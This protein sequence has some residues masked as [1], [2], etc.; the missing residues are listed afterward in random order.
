MFNGAFY[1]W[2][3]N[4]FDIGTSYQLQLHRKIGVVF[5]SWP[6]I[7]QFFMIV[8]SAFLIILALCMSISAHYYAR[9]KSKKELTFITDSMRSFIHSNSDDLTLPKEYS[10]IE[11]DN[12]FEIFYRLD[13][14]RSTNTG[15]AGLGLAIAKEIVTAHGGTITAESNSENTKFTVKLPS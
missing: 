13:S 11:S 9:Y 14:A 1:D 8:F 12:I 4:R 3:S 15:G 6:E 2:F 10:E 7:K 5:K